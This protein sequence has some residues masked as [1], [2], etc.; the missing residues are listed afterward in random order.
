MNVLV[1]EDDPATQMIVRKCLER[2]GYGVT[3]V[4]AT[5]VDAI[6]TIEESRPDIVLCDVEIA[7]AMDGIEAAE[8][9]KDRFGLPVV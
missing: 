6:S 4:V 7:G 9:I 2:L 3:G 5:A 1:V 8:L